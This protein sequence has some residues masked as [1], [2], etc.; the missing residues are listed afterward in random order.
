MNTGS[1]RRTMSRCRSNSLPDKE[2]DYRLS[3]PDLRL[4]CRKSR[5]QRLSCIVYC[6]LFEWFNFDE[7]EFNV[8]NTYKSNQI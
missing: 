3:D 2:N 6:R 8:Y 4:S 7:I 1:P 5:N